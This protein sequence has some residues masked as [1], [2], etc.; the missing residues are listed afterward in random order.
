MNPESFE[1][2]LFLARDIEGNPNYQEFKT[3][4]LLETELSKDESFV[5]IAPFGSK[6]EGHS[7]QNKSDTDVLVLFD[8]GDN[9]KTGDRYNLLNKINIWKNEDEKNRLEIH[10]IP[11]DINIK[12]LTLCLE[13]GLKEDYFESRLITALAGMSKI[14]TGNKINNYRKLIA[15][16]LNLLSLEKKEE[17]ADRIIKNIMR[18]EHMS[19]PKKETRLENLKINYWK[20]YD[21]R[22]KMWKNRVQKIWNLESEA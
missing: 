8:S 5:G 13:Q 7:E 20:I 4:R 15:E 12:E 2:K 14:V 18:N 10:P 21:E 9:G 16:K 22:K 11:R 6:M 19:F 17:L 1:K 3:I